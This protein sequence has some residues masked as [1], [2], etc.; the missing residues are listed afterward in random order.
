MS[1]LYDKGTITS[2]FD[3][4]FVARHANCASVTVWIYFR[5]LFPVLV[6]LYYSR[7][8]KNW[9]GFNVRRQ[10]FRKLR[11]KREHLFDSRRKNA[12]MASVDVIRSHHESSSSFQSRTR[13]C[14]RDRKQRRGEKCRCIV[15]VYR[16]SYDNSCA[17]GFPRKKV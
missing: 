8:N 2:T 13:A 14:P 1:N 16:K 11:D 7:G 10:A 9:R 6:A 3:S 15:D 17:R 4:A 12:Q 5:L